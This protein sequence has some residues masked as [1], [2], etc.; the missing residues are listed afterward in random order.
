MGTNG[1]LKH[2]KRP[3]VIIL[4]ERKKYLFPKMWARGVGGGVGEEREEKLERWITG[5]LS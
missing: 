5:D 3:S 2:M 4:N 1:N